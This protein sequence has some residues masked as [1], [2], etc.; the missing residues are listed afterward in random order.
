MRSRSHLLINL[1]CLRDN[2]QKLKELAPKPD[3]L[4][5]VKANA[6]G[7]GIE[8]I[9]DYSFHELGVSSFGVAS[10]KEAVNLRRSS[11]NYE[12][13]LYV[14]SDLSLVDHREYY[15]DYKLLPVIS[16]L[17]DLKFILSHSQFRHLPL[18]L[19]FDTGMNRLGLLEGDGEW[20]I[21]EL[22]K[23]GRGVYH[24]MTHFSDSFLP[25]REKT[26]V[27]YKRFLR[28]KEEFLRG[29]VEVTHTSVANSGAVEN[30]IGLEET[31]IRP[32]LMLY[33]SQST[34]GPFTWK[35]EPISSLF[36]EI[37]Q[38]QIISARETVGYGS[39]DLPAR[40]KEGGVLC[41]LALGYGD[42]LSNQYQGLSVHKGEWRGE[43]FGR[44]NM[45]MIQVIFPRGTPIRRGDLLPLWTH[46]KKRLN[47]ISQKTGLIP[48]EITTFLRNRIARI[49]IK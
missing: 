17:E 8:R 30:G 46:S 11:E 13:E 32:G 2:F 37:L 39:F 21:R 44:I 42:G 31:M 47:Y 34:E 43:I 24:L 23:R 40:W 1:S 35:G 26:G 5:M 4:F 14:F 45:D 9:V 36:A 19:F 33:G 28:L 25:E 48:Y 6:Y 20:I 29:G 16:H 27:Q 7:H 18:V 15:L 49:Y 41:I 12:P 3:V 38:A 22:K 10:L